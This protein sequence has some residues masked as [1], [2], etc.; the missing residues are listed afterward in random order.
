M[1]KILS[2]AVSFAQD[3][4][5]NL[6]GNGEVEIVIAPPFTALSPLN[7]ALRDTS[8][9]LAAQNLFYMPEGAFT[10]EISSVMLKDVGCDYVIIGH[11]ERRDLFGESNELIHKKLSAALNNELVPILCVGERLKERRIGQTENVL[12]QQLDSALQDFRST[13]IEALVI[14]YEP[15]WA[16]GTGETALP[17]DAQAGALFIRTRLQAL[18]NAKIAKAVR[19]QYGGSVK[20][21]NAEELLVQP[22][23]DGALVGGSSLDPKA[24][25]K[26]IQAAARARTSK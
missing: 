12:A 18:F 10:G 2:E 11:S 14:A 9:K 23:I 26:I 19:I 22:D 5:S 16:I 25:L 15:V 24:F 6:N 21:E 20:P 8:I 1:H 17:E 3:L 13:D 7:E 4:L